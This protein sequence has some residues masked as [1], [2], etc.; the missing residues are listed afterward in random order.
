[1]IPH[2]NLFKKLKYSHSIKFLVEKFINSN[3]DIHKSV[4]FIEKEVTNQAQLNIPLTKI[5]NIEF[6]TEK[7]EYYQKK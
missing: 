3:N 5:N 1:M 6:K 4:S 7:V 2:L